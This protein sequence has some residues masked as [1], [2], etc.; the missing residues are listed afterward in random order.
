MSSKGQIVIPKSIRDAL[1]LE[2]GDELEAEVT[3]GV[4]NLH[5]RDL[6]TITDNLKEEF[7]DADMVSELEED[8]RKDIDRGRSAC[9]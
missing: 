5:P 3:D 9:S 1:G 7:S 4:I 8:H 2:P 6:E